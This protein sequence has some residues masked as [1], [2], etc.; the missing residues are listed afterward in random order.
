MAWRWTATG[1]L[2]IADFRDNNRIRKVD[3]TGTITTIAGNGPSGGLGIYGGDG[4]PAVDAQLY[5][6][7]DVALDG[8]G[9]LY[10]ADKFGNDRIR[11]VDSTGTITT[12]A[13]SG[14]YAGSAGTAARRSM[15]RLWNPNGVAVDTAGNV[16][17]RRYGATAGS[18]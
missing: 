9:N 14:G 13:G 16:L 6:P 7:S 2:Y 4:G 12:I 1:T 3:S 17:H 8:A 15:A 10:I 11:K 5:F 18:E